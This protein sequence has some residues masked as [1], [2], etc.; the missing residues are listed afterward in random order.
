NAQ[1]AQMSEL[2]QLK[3]QLQALQQKVEALEQ[4]QSV[5]DTAAQEQAAKLEALQKQAT[6]TEAA[7]EHATDAVAQT[8]T[9]L[10]EWVSRFQWK[11]D[12]RYRNEDIKQEFAPERD[13]DR[14]RARFGFA[15]KVNDTVRTEMQLTTGESL[16]NG[17]YGD[18]RSSNQTLTDA[19]SRKRI[20]LDTAFAEWAPNANWKFTLGK[21]R[22]PYYRPTTSLFFDSDINPEGAAVNWQQG[23]DGVFASAFYFD[24]TERATTTD[25]TLSGA[26]VG[27]RGDVASGMR[28]TVAASYFDNGAVEGWNA[29]QDATL[30]GNAFGNTTTTSTAV[31]RTGVLTATNTACIANDFNIVEALAELSMQVGGR[32]LIFAVDYAK[33]NKADFSPTGSGLD[34]AYNAG[35]QYGKV[36][37]AH[38]WEVGYLYQKVEND[39]LYGQFFDSD[40]AGGTT[41]SKGHVFKIGYGFGKNFRINGTY[42]LNDT[43]IDVPVTIGGVPITD[44]HYRR[45]QIDLNVGF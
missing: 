15:A 39:A 17:G 43:N 25:S 40:F 16:S 4:Q 32:P 2:E 45:L 23:A 42:F 30:P 37:A 31:C 35:I 20:W 9:G 21:M 12:F 36:A 29:V 18:A 8:R 24:L 1:S 34:T 11:G 26:Q 44:R 3:A 6:A 28:L 5:K 14:I 19:N 38:T 7:A 22:Y 13:R 33:N 41:G 10:P 27:W